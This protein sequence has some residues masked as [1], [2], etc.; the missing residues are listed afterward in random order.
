MSKRKFYAVKKGYKCGIYSTPMLNAF[1]CA[2]T[3]NP[4]PPGC[5]CGEPDDRFGD[6]RGGV[7]IVRKEEGA[8]LYKLKGITTEIKEE[9]IVEKEEKEVI[10][11]SELLC[12]SSGSC[13]ENVS[14]K[15]TID[16]TLTITGQGPMCDYDYTNK[17]PFKEM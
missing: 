6:E 14:Y 17:S 12:V 10:K 5:T 13:G 4:L 7:G 3:H 2:M 16:S 9:K 8:G 15:L 11:E 1:G